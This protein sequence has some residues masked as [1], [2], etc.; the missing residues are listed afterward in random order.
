MQAAFAGGRDSGRI[1]GQARRH[2]R[3][4][5]I[6]IARDHHRRTRCRG[7]DDDISRQARQ[8]A[9]PPMIRRVKLVDDDVRARGGDHQRRNKLQR[10][11]YHMGITTVL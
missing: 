3:A 6:N 8:I 5:M 7:G 9:A 4:I 1:F 10:R 2:L 11:L